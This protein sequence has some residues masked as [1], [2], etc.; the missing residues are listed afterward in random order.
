MRCV[1]RVTVN[2]FSMI[3]SDKTIKNML[4]T[5][6]LVIDPIDDKSIQPASVDLRLG[7]HFLV[8]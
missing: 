8:V 6:D 4:E 3:L 7:D 2:N 5:G 1:K